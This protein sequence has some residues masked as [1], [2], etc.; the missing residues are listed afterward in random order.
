[1][2]RSFI[3]RSMVASSLVFGAI[4]MFQGTALRGADPDPKAAQ[5]RNPAREHWE[6]VVT[7][8]MEEETAESSLRIRDQD[9][10]E[11]GWFKFLELWQFSPKEGRW[12]QL[13]A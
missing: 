6:K 12:I 9:V 4:F 13:K 1:M 8:F 3:W 10:R 2:L 11:R 5:A 7:W